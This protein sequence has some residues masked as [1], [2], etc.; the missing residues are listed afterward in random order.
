MLKYVLHSP[1]PDGTWR[2]WEKCYTVAVENTSGFNEE[3]VAIFDDMIEAERVA[4]GSG[5]RPWPINIDVPA[6]RSPRPKE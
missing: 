3:C 2:G 6:I 4:Y 5:F 1:Y